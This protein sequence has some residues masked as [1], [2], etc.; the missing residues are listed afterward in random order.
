MPGST[1]NKPDHN[2][3]QPIRFLAGVEPMNAT[4]AKEPKWGRVWRYQGKRGVVWRIRYTDASGRRILETLGRE[5]AWTHQLAEKELRRRLVDVERDGYRKP[6]KLTFE[7]F[8][9]RWLNEYLPGR[10]LK[11]TTTDGYRQS[12]N[13]HL[14][15]ALGNYPLERLE[16]EPQLLDHY[17][18]RK[19]QQGLSAKTITNQLLLL[20]VMLKT[21]V[22]WRLI[23]H[24]PVRD[25][26]RPRLHQ[27]EPQILDTTEI[28]RLDSAYRGLQER[29]ESEEEREWWRIAHILTFTALGTALRRG[30]LLAL[31][32]Q[33]IHLLDNHLHVRQALVRGR[34]TT[35]KSRA[36]H[37]TVQLGAHTT[38]LLAT[39]YQHSRYSSD[40]DYVFHHPHKGTPLD[41]SRLSRT[42]LHPAL[43]AAG[44]SKT[45]RP[46]HDLRHTAL[47]HD[48]AAGNPLT[49]IQ[50]KAGHSQIAIT[51]RYIHAAQVQ[52]AGAAERAERR[53]FGV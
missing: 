32:W 14:L 37:R 31:Q 47:T 44:I 38:K 3:A 27:P 6:E 39:H 8:T 43:R 50:M 19:T 5:P 18:T 49:Y 42:Y 26:D 52:F 48:A 46:F 16:R 35:P 51:Q 1:N 4:M 7:A 20:Q 28:A 13:R 29:A 15:P 21:A 24:N 17:I 53:M 23:R 25:I 12:L 2:P 36:G 10:N 40:T 41:P 22:R 33:D 9:E 45:I 11:K 30:E 34:L